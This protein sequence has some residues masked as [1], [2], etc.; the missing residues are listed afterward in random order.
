MQRSKLMTTKVDVQVFN[1]LPLKDLILFPFKVFQ[2][3]HTSHENIETNITV[4]FMHVSCCKY[5]RLLVGY[6]VMEIEIKISDD[7]FQAKHRLTDILC[8]GPEP[9][10]LIEHRPLIEHR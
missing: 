2:H 8:T 3:E 10:I 7:G 6:L 5:I 1:T 4:D 9:C